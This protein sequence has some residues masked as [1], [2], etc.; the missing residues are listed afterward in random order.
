MAPGYHRLTINARAP[1]QESELF[2]DVAMIPGLGCS[3]NQLDLSVSLTFLFSASLFLILTRINSLSRSS[4]NEVFQV[5][6]R[7]Q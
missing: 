3:S 2:D 7:V 1:H 5:L 4:F 6:C